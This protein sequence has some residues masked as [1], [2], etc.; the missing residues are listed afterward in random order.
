V[1]WGRPSAT[2][3]RHDPPSASLVRR[4][5]RSERSSRSTCRVQ[6][7][8]CIPR[9]VFRLT[10]RTLL[11]MKQMQ[12]PPEPPTDAPPSA[13]ER[14]G[15]QR[16]QRWRRRQHY[17]VAAPAAAR[18][19]AQPLEHNHSRAQQAKRTQ[20]FRYAQPTFSPEAQ[21]TSNPSGTQRRVCSLRVR[22]PGGTL[23]Q[24]CFQPMSRVRRAHAGRPATSLLATRGRCIATI[25]R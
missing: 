4:S 13:Q 24:Q 1:D 3:R 12:T 16:Q 6:T 21:P 9:K 2:R 5:R 19:G 11:P 15:Q 7:A 17:Q 23:S 14:R 20:V 8:I 25:C 22:V 18:Q 10:T